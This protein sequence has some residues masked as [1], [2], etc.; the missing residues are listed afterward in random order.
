MT[1]ALI[2]LLAVA[3][4][5]GGIMLIRFLMDL[6]WRYKGRNIKPSVLHRLDEKWLHSRGRCGSATFCREC[7][8]C[9]ECVAEIV[10]DLKAE[11]DAETEGGAT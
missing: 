6:P 9:D 7:E 8:H 1:F 5:C 10:K 2:L 11:I 3:A 4:N